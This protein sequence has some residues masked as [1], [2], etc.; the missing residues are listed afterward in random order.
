MQ[1]AVQPQTINIEGIRSQLA[2]KLAEFLFDLFWNTHIKDPLH[3]CF[4]REQMGVDV[5]ERHG[6]LKTIA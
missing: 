2:G 3:Q 1:Q 6:L 5:F 4:D